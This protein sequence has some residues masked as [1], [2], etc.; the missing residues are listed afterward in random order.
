M[1]RLVILAAGVLLA[2]AA[3]APA[4]PWC[5]CGVHCLEPRPDHPDCSDACEHRLRL[6]TFGNTDKIL[7]K[8]HSDCC[9]DRICAVRKLGCRFH[10]D[11]CCDQAAFDALLQALLL[12]PCWEVRERAAWSLR[13]QNARTPCAL[14][15]LYV[16]SK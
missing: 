3:A 2:A 16:S 11:I 13:L 6:P 15:A 4:G 5:C 9:C 8:L 10:V 7:E 14:L 12:D 1:K